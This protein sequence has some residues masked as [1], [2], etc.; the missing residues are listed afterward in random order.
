M[1]AKSVGGEY[2][3][4]NGE[5]LQQVQSVLSGTVARLLAYPVWVSLSARQSLGSTSSRPP[6]TGL[7]SPPHLGQQDP[8]HPAQREE[9]DQEVLPFSL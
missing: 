9:H 5:R 3:E 4:A 8:Q 2:R 6:L 7:T 1:R